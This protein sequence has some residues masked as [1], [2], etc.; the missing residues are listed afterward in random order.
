MSAVYFVLL[1]IIAAPF[2]GARAH[3]VVAPSGLT[4][5]YSGLKSPG[6]LS[7]CSNTDC[8]PAEVT[9]DGERLLIRRRPEYGFDDDWEPVRDAA[10]LPISLDGGWHM[11]RMPSDSKARCIIRPPEM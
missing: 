1:T 11:C 2:I 6:G 8:A 9:F 3:E 7:C 10:T 4:I 5:S